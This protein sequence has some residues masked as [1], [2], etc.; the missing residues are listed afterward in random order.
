MVRSKAA[1]IFVLLLAFLITAQVFADDYF[2]YDAEGQKILFMGGK[3]TEFVE[4]LDMDK[5]PD[6]LMPTHNPDKFLAIYL[7][8]ITEGKRGIFGNKK[9]EDIVK[10]GELILFNVATGRTEDLIQ[11]GFSP[12]NYEYTEDHRHFVITYRTGRADDSTFEILY[13]NIPEQKS[14]KLT[15]PKWTKVVNQIVISPQSEQILLL[16]DNKKR[17]LTIKESKS[18]YGSFGK[19]SGSPELVTLSFQPLAVK[20]E[21]AL[22]SCPLWM[23]SITPERAVLI[24]QNYLN[25][26]DAKDRSGDYIG[27]GTIRLLN[28]KDHSIIKDYKTYP[29]NIYHHWYEK[30]KVL[31]LNYYATESGLRKDLREIYMKIDTASTMSNEFTIP[32][33]NFEYLGDKNC[34]YVITEDNLTVIDYKTGDTIPCETGSNSSAGGYY[35]FLRVPDTDVA[36]IYKFEKSSVKFFDLNENRIIKKVICGRGLLK[37]LNSMYRGFLGRST[38]T[39]TT[40]SVSPDKSKFFIYNRLSDDVTVY[41]Q[42]YEKQAFISVKNDTCL[43]MYW[44]QK[45]ALQTILI[46]KKK[47]YKLDYDNNMLIPLYTFAKGI[48]AAYLF[49]DETRSMV[50]S[51]NEIVVLDS[52]NLEVKNNFKL[53]IEKKEPD[54][55]LQPGD[56]QYYFI[57]NL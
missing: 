25:I 47:I 35:E 5:N 11:L 20:N 27:A 14:Q 30:D 52:K 49:S 32:T 56:Q 41:D 15:L 18:G 44:V 22:E 7:P 39:E 43:G 53:F 2:L 4:K 29:A 38:G 16:L 57:P 13:Y 1:L 8:E 23:Y 21:L 48:A 24:C 36:A 9:E 31:I 6:Y 37:A 42:N 50:L 40:I 55:K 34:L 26:S 45:P 17:K 19:I 33:G 3:S 54:M 10:A 51:D 46:G 28:P 12:F